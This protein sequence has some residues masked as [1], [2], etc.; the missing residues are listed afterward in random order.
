MVTRLT[1]M[2]D[3]LFLIAGFDDGVLRVFLLDLSLG[4]FEQT[5]RLKLI[6]MTITCL[7]Y[8]HATDTLVVAGPKSDLV[9]VRNL[10]CDEKSLEVIRSE[11]AIPNDGVS[12]LVFSPSGE[13][14]ISGGWDGK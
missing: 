9:L 7:A 1:Q 8:S 2:N 10:L 3:K 6:T 14:I 13:I 12:D 5:K 11:K 4:Q